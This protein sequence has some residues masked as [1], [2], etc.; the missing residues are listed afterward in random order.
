MGLPQ[1]SEIQCLRSRVPVSKLSLGS[2]NPLILI[3]ILNPLSVPCPLTSLVGA[4]QRRWWIF[5]AIIPF[6]V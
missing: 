5:L 1:Q 6:L 3:T 4:A 2:N